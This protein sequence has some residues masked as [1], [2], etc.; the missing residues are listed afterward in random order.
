MGKVMTAGF[1]LRKEAR[2]IVDE[3]CAAKGMNKNAV[4][5]HVMLWFL[6]QA[7]P[8]QSVVAGLV[9]EE[10]YDAYADALE[11]IAKELRGFDKLVGHAGGTG[12]D[13]N[14]RNKADVQGLPPMKGGQR[15][16]AQKA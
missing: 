10:M 9:D 11:R 15:A 16:G 7:P 2:R 4:V 5:E 12:A 3:F 14:A 13:Q 1:E 8:V 6:R